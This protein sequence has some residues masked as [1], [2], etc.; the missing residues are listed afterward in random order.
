MD[1][2]EKTLVEI[3]APHELARI[4]AFKKIDKAITDILQ[5]GLHNTTME[6]E[7]KKLNNKP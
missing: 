6:K 5:R 3:L 2:Q 1:K 4:E 7:L